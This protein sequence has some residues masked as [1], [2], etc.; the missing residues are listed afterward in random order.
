[1]RIIVIVAATLSVVIPAGQAQTKAQC[2]KLASCPADGCG[3][4][5][6]SDLNKQKN[7]T[8]PPSG[9]NSMSFAEFV[10]LNSKAVNKDMR[11]SWTD[12]ERA[13][14]TDVENGP[15]VTLT[16]FLFDATQSDP[17]TCNCYKPTPNRDYHIWLAE[18]KAGA[19]KKKFVVVEMTP[20]VR[21]NHAG[22]KLQAVEAL[23]PKTGK[24]WTL[25]RVRGY[26][27]FDN[28]HW[29]FPKRKIRATAWEIHPIIEF[30]Y[31]TTGD[32]CDP[33]TN[34]GWKNLDQ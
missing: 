5:R 1:M 26:A 7:R 32:N 21:K 17:E 15:G 14:V 11:S 33:T 20:R 6:D 27:L 13:G 2:A 30:S 3:S 29:N 28:E 31:C 9:F 18:N 25:V 8:T 4:R 16:A 34:Q 10:A 19:K 12:A 24:P 22:W 23:K